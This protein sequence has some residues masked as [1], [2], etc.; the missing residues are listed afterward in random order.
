[1]LDVTVQPLAAE[2]QNTGFGAERRIQRGVRRYTC[3]DKDR[4]SAIGSSNL[5]RSVVLWSVV[6]VFQ[7][8]LAA[9]Q[10]ARCRPRFVC[11]ANL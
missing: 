10:Y 8:L 7:C 2:P 11:K 4:M 3:P 5:R 1:M 6:N 9:K